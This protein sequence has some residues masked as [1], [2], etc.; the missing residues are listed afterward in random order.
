MGGVFFAMKA[1]FRENPILVVSSYLVLSLL[2]IGFGV[3]IGEESIQY[4]SGLN[5]DYI[6]NSMWMVYVIITTVGYGDFVT[7]SYLARFFVFITSILG[8]FLISLVNV[9]IN[10]YVAFSEVENRVNFF[11][12]TKISKILGLFK[13]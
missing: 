12:I 5:F 2:I 4:V 13:N 9:S 8:P 11:Y 7:V 1:E 10:N 6:E 3:K